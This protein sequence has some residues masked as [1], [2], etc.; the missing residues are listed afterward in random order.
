MGD[1]RQARGRVVA[2]ARS[3]LAGGVVPT[4]ADV[5][6]AAGMS[7]STYYRLA[8]GSHRALLREAGHVER[9]SARARVLDAT[10]D[11][12]GEVG[13]GG[14]LMDAV[15]ERA[16]V[17]RPTLYRLFPGKAELL[18]E[19]A[20]T[21]TPL[22]A[23]SQG[24]AT[25]ADRPPEDVLPPLVE[26]AVPQL[27]ASRG[28]LR[29]VLAEV[30]AGGAEGGVGR[31]VVA[32]AYAALATYLQGQ[33][34]TGRLRQVDLLAAVQALLGPLLLHAVVQPDV[35]TDVIAD[36]PPPEQTAADIVQL[37]LRG[38]RPDADDVLPDTR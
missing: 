37:W 12:L 36:P 7:R 11:L 33:M 2:A 15:A 31:A 10:A 28:V 35:W 29:A 9:R 17:S 5:A 34:V 14:L 24:L 18:A 26:A 3:L 16:G 32:G 20:R 30:S 8:G 4:A 25:L 23:L 27:L 13:G 19:L 38:L 1:D 6:T 22:A 21:H